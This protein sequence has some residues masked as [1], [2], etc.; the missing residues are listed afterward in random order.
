MKKKKDSSFK[1]KVQKMIEGKGFYI[2][3]TAL[4][5]LVSLSIYARRLQVKKQTEQLS[6]D[7]DAWQ[8][9]LVESGVEFNGSY[10]DENCITP[11]DPTPSEPTSAPESDP[12][13]ATETNAPSP[14]QTE[15][16]AVVTETLPIAVEAMSSVPPQSNSEEMQMPCQGELIEDCS[17]DNLVYCLAMDDWRTHNGLDIAAKEGSPVVASADGTISQIY[18]DDLLGIVIT[19]DHGNGISTLYANLQ[20]ATF[21]QVG[22]EVKAGD[23]IGGIGQPGA[24][25]ADKDPH[26]HFEICKNGEPQNPHNYIFSQ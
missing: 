17:L 4:V 16:T 25:E 5:L 26:L 9:A 22:T 7:E 18:E 23:V 14:S 21:I 1:D 6:F 2:A 24:L 15:S 13:P 11:T 3:L 12:V 8:E 20:S 10:P 19:I